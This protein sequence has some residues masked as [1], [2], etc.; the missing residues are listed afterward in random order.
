ML[1]GDDVAS[2][3]RRCAP[4]FRLLRRAR[5]RP[6]WTYV[7]NVWSGPSPAQAAPR[8]GAGRVIHVARAGAG[9]MERTLISLIHSEMGRCQSKQNWIMA[10]V[11]GLNSF[12]VLND[13][14]LRAVLG[15]I[16]CGAI[17]AMGVS[18]VLSIWGSVGGRPGRSGIATAWA[19]SE[20]DRAQGGG[21]GCGCHPSRGSGP[22][23]RRAR[24]EPARRAWLPDHLSGRRR[25]RPSDVRRR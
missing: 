15:C 2:G 23:G 24:R 9:V 19:S 22:P 1:T 12:I 6:E 13:E 7:S 10:A 17:A 3:F 16:T 5:D 14:V 11:F 4:A 25:T 8:R 20:S 18:S 21:R